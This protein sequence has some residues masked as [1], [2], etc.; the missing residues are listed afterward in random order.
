MQIKL[1]K[2]KEWENIKEEV[3]HIEESTFEE[4]IRYD[5]DSDD[6]DS[7]KNPHAIN[8]L[9]YDEN[10]AVGYLMSTR[11][12]DDE[13]C[14][15]DKEYGKHTTFYL[16]SIAFLP[17]CQGKGFGRKV[18]ARWLAFVKKRG[19]KRIV[20]DATSEGMRKLALAHGFI[21][22]RHIKNWQGRENWKM[23]KI[24]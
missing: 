16:E 13:R 14:K 15:R 8:Y 18:F 21:K 3:H 24:L 10:I 19:Y 17:A 6:F 23:E 4:D 1:V 11:L 9:I 20:L 7:F 2:S 5:R 22:V 12:E